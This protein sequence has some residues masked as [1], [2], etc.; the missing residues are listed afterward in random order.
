[1]LG[2]QEL[3]GREVASGGLCVLHWACLVLV[4]LCV[5][6]RNGAGEE[7]STEG[8]VPRAAVPAWGQVPQP[9]A[10]KSM[11]LAVFTARVGVSFEC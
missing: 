1:M 9:G 8:C 4:W 10:G 3:A 6:A 11:L 5:G 2:S 7:D